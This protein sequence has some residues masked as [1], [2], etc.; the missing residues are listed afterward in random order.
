MVWYGMVW[1]GM[2]CIMCHRTLCFAIHSH[3]CLLMPSVSSNSN[4]PVT[5]FVRAGLLKQPLPKQQPELKKYRSK[6]LPWEE[7]AR[8]ELSRS[9]SGEVTAEESPVEVFVIPCF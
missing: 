9:S 3:V 8:I 1:Y 5:S 2:V 4:G 6:S 7:A